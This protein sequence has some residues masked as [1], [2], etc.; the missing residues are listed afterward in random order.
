VKLIEL[1][2]SEWRTPLDF[3]DALLS[4]LGAPD[5]HGRNIN[6][7]IDS[8]VGGD[9]NAVEPPYRIEVTGLSKASEEAFDELIQSFAAIAREGHATR[10][11]S[12]RATLS[13]AKVG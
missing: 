3:Y 9:I 10:I 12:D 6:A 1:D 8:M 4:S 11:T 7:L 5:W 13:R 2:A